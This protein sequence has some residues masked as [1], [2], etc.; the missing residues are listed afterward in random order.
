M[1]EAKIFSLV[2][3]SELGQ[4]LVT[5][6]EVD[7]TR[8]IPIWI[9]PGEGMAI[10]A[11]LQGEPFPRPLTHDLLKNILEVLDVEVKHIVVTELKDDT[12]YANIKLAA[13]KR[14]LDLDARPSDSLALA[15]KCKA[16]IYIDDR[17]FKECPVIHKPITD[18]EVDSF[19]RSLE[20]LRPDDF[21][22]DRKKE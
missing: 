16:P 8:L 4:Y 11:V 7:G 18:H 19:K 22:K 5:L 10:A 15:L 12:F 1:R 3:V 20:K 14:E 17:V 13:G 21:F 2:V 9:G 6:E